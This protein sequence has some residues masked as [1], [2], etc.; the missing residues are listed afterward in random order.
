M[1]RSRLLV[2]ALLLAL[3]PLVGCMS[4]QHVAYEPVSQAAKAESAPRHATAASRE[5]IRNG[6]VTLEVADTDKAR[7][8]IEE[9]AEALGGF[10]ERNE[11][12]RLV[13]KI[14]TTKMKE[15][16][17]ALASIGRVIGGAW[18]AQDV[19]AAGDDARSRIKGLQ[20]EI[21]RLKELL[22]QAKDGDAQSRL[23]A[24]LQAAQAQWTGLVEEMRRHDAQ[25]AMATLDIRLTLDPA[26]ACVGDAIPVQWVRSM[27]GV[28]NQ[29]RGVNLEGIRDFKSLWY[30]PSV[31][32]TFPASF[33]QFRDS[34][35]GDTE[36]M[37]AVDAHSNRL[38]VTRHG[39]P[40][41]AAS[42]F[43]F[44]LVRRGVA[45]TA[46][47]TVIKE[48]ELKAARG[49]AA[50]LVVGE[51]R[52]GEHALAYAV[53][54]AVSDDHVYT[55]EMWGTKAQVEALGKELEVCVASLKAK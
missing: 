10:V 49:Q 7:A 52:V 5:V 18:T 29:P 19:T 54:T 48:T 23:N 28:L 36:V 38:R 53:A 42:V 3:S 31:D 32:V 1:N 11:S 51:R 14:P 37:E 27:A 4:A 22:A 44:P 33:T 34:R 41:S 20:G 50:H 8:Q 6:Q 46:G 13:V 35:V 43:W 30:S 26:L 21:A 12:A 40:G 45:E 16:A 55:V 25:T 2:A 24:Q 47:V 9:Q 39:N 15:A 17:D